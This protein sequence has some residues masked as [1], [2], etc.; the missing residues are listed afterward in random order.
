MLGLQCATGSV[1]FNYYQF[2]MHGFPIISTWQELECQTLFLLWNIF[3]I[4]KIAAWLDS[5]G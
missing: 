3:K 2:S 1:L 5:L 4:E